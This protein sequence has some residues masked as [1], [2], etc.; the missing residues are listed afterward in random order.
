MKSTYFGE[1]W[2]LDDNIILLMDLME[3]YGPAYIPTYYLYNVI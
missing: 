2:T 1:K 3:K